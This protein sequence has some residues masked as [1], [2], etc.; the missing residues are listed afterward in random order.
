MA[1]KSPEQIRAE[2][3]Q[4]ENRIRQLAAS[5]DQG[6][7]YLELFR[8]TGN[9]NWL[10]TAH[11]STFSGV[12]GGVAA[13]ANLDLQRQLG[14][15][16]PGIGFLSTQVAIDEIKSFFQQFEQTGAYNWSFN[17]TIESARATWRRYNLEAQFPGAALG[18]PD[19]A[20]L[21]ANL[22]AP[23]ALES[24]E[25]LLNG[26]WNKFG[27]G[28]ADYKRHAGFTEFSFT[29]DGVTMEGVPGGGA[30]GSAK[31]TYVV[32][33][34]GRVE[35]VQVGNTSGFG[36]LDTLFP[37]VGAA[38]LALAA[39]LFGNPSLNLLANAYL[40][41]TR[42]SYA[43]VRRG[44]DATNMSVGQVQAIIDGLR[45]RL[46]GDGLRG[47]IP[48]SAVDE[49]ASD[50]L[51]AAKLK[52]AE[53][54]LRQVIVYE[55]KKAQDRLTIGRWRMGAAVW[56]INRRRASRRKSYAADRRFSDICDHRGEHF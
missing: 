37:S 52:E 9:A 6:R 10:V 54:L 35:F 15:A 23:G 1:G 39:S 3:R 5:G 50:G 45:G 33:A 31:I 12:V 16:Y 29:V 2:L 14:A 55:L 28:L 20:S 44:T 26:G 4:S 32:N 49:G 30:L 8:I 7:A 22:S 21:L 19:F 40:D 48:I 17:K 42:A 36:L 56:L 27:G 46:R 11:V 25:A 38:R 41:A 18:N 24:L 13:Q 34:D 47:R 51:L 53:E 43:G